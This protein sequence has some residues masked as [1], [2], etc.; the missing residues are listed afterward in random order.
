MGAVYVDSAVG[1]DL[2]R[3]KLFSG[4]LF[5]FSPSANSAGLCGVA[6]EMARGGVRPPRPDGRAGLNDGRGLRTD[7]RGSQAGVHPRS[8]RKKLIGGLL[9]DLGC[10]LDRT[11]FD[12]PAPS[13]D[14]ARRVHEGR[15]R[16]AVPSASRHVVLGTVRAAELVAAGVR[17]RVRELDGLPSALL[18]P[19]DGEQLGELRLRRVEPLRTPAGRAADQEGHPQAAEAQ[20]QLE[21]DPEIRVV[22]PVGGVLSSRRRT[23]T[24]RCRTRPTARDSAS[25]S[26]RS[27][28]T[29]SSSG[30]PLRNVDSACTGTTL[31]D[32]VRASDL[33]PLPEDL[34]DRYS[35]RARAR[36]R[37]RRS[38]QAPPGT[39]Q[40]SVAA[41]RPG[42]SSPRQPSAA[43]AVSGSTSIRCSS[44]RTATRAELGRTAVGPT[45]STIVATTS[46]T[47]AEM[48][49]ADVDR[50][51]LDA[52]A[53]AARGRPGDVAREDEIEQTFARAESR[54]PRLREAS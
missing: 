12:V 19:L 18:R 47:D 24:R 31:G 54:A 33:E 25:T 40:S 44:G 29:I 7:P 13:H 3:E 51:A 38:R 41:P 34:I 9:A 2:R 21:L 17:D 1:D 50:R 22:S 35:G 20:E 4:E 28:S 14:G 23:C 10:D 16:A 42:G 11:Y 37:A 30:V 5:V 45:S 6:R 15:A 52:G 27:T 48:P 49:H 36:R 53:T 46:R 26:G 32:F 39:R 43:A 8:A